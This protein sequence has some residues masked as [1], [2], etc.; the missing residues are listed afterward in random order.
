MN[1]KILDLENNGKDLEHMLTKARKVN[2]TKQK[3]MWRLE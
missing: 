1:F 3:G 2:N